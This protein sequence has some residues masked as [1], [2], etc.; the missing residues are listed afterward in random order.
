MSRISAYVLAISLCTLADVASAGLV[1]SSVTGNLSISGGTNYF[2][3]S[4]GFVPAGC[5][6]SGI[7]G[8][9]VT[10]VNPT[11]EFCFQ[12]GINTDTAN[13]TDNVL[14]FTDVSSAGSAPVQ[15]TFAF[16]PGLVL[17]VS[18]TFDNFLEGG[19]TA[20][21]LNDSSRSTSHSI[22]LAGRTR[23]LTTS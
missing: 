4:N 22:S 17:S 3:S 19:A 20:T 23:R 11:P 7:S 16:S 9:T 15:L 18:E 21:F 5:Q 1:G 6:N 10:V 2:D 12:D 8:T 14:T 13:F